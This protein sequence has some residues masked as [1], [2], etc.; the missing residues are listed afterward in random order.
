MIMMMSMMMMNANFMSNL[1]QFCAVSSTVYSWWSIVR[2]VHT[3]QGEGCVKLFWLIEE[4]QSFL[5]G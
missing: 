1:F 3:I 2:S 5:Y 4:G